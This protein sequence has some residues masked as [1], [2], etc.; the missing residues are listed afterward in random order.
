M[1][2]PIEDTLFETILSAAKDKYFLKQNFHKTQDLDSKIESSE[3]IHFS[4]VKPYSFI[5]SQTTHI[6]LLGYG[7]NRE[8]R[9]S[10]HLEQE[11]EIFKAVHDNIVNCSFSSQ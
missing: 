11:L 6:T 1:S 4:H 3:D 10:G 8:C 7:F 9:L 2:D 5:H